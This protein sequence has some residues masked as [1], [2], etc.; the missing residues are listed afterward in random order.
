MESV[1][2][3]YPT[4]H[5]K[6]DGRIACVGRFFLCV[7]SPP[8]GYTTWQWSIIVA[9]NYG[10]ENIATMIDCSAATDGI[11]EADMESATRAVWERYCSWIGG[12]VQSEPVNP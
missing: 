6:K 4:W 12:S 3:Q 9:N 11:G 8:N 5:E 2:V 10:N 1:T 7:M